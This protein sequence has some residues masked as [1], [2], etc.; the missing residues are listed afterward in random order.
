MQKILNVVFLLALLGGARTDAAAVELLCELDQ[1]LSVV[2]DT[3]RD[4]A[5][6]LGWKGRM[7]SM[8]R[9]S[10][11]TGAHRFEDQS[12]GLIWISI[13]DKAM[14]LDSHKGEPVANGCRARSGVRFAR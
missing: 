11:S 12:S 13:P 4:N 8:Q 10:T 3:I 14:L 9:V 7:Y 5:I 1:R 2:G 6:E